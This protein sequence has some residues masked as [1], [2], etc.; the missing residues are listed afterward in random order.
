MHGYLNKF[1]SNKKKIYN[2]KENEGFTFRI[3]GLGRDDKNNLYQKQSHSTQDSSIVTIGVDEIANANN[4]N[5]SKITNH[6]FLVWGDNNQELTIETNE[7]SNSQVPLMKRKWKIQVTGETVSGLNTTIEFEDLE[8]TEKYGD[9]Y[10]LVID[11]SADGT[12]SPENTR[13]IKASEVENN[14]ISFSDVQW[15]LDK[16]G[17]DIF[18]IGRNTELAVTLNEEKPISCE[19]VNNG[20]LSYEVSGGIEPYT[21][22]LINSNLKMRQWYSINKCSVCTQWYSTNKCTVFR[23]LLPTLCNSKLRVS[24]QRTPNRDL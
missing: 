19:K 22:E 6:T 11:N 5:K 13:Y 2:I 20:V 4:D 12:F 7:R 9:D 8:Q 1:R 23:A 24:Q 18:T 17:S 21:F 3:A 16:S 14:I 10:L 15:D